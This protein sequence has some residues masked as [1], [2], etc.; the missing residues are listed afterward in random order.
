MQTKGKPTVLLICGKS[1]KDDF[2]RLHHKLKMTGKV[3][4]YPDPL[5]PDKDGVVMNNPDLIVS[6][7]VVSERSFVEEFFRL[8]EIR[9]RTMDTLVVLYTD[10]LVFK[11]SEIATF[12]NAGADLFSSQEPRNPELLASHILRALRFHPRA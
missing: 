1:N 6:D 5:D 3:D 9:G 4:V 10:P 8:S 12:A 2:N 11:S 7:L